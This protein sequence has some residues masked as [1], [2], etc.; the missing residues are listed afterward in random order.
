MNRYSSLKEYLDKNSPTINCEFDLFA[1][2]PNRVK[3]PLY[4]RHITGA[5]LFADLP[6]YSTF[7]ENFSPEECAYMTNHFFSWINATAI[8]LNGGIIDKF[9]GDEIMIIFSPEF[10][11][12]D[13]LE[14]AI[15]TAKGILESDTFEK[16]DDL[17]YLNNFT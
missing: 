12:S 17:K 6:G 11:N 3:F 7:A 1:Y 8:Q 14:S 16:G 10:H 2:Q 4:G 5:V 9:I 15:K 13:P